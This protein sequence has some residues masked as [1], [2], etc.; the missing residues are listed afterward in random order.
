MQR[1]IYI[2]GNWK[3]NTTLSEAMVLS[4][5]VLKRT[6]KLHHINI[7]LAPPAIWLVPIR[8][9]YKRA[10]LAAQNIYSA[11][12]G[13]YTGEISALMLKGIAQYVI[14]GHSERRSLF[15]ED[16]LLISAKIKT[17]LKENITPILAIG[18]EKKLNLEGLTESGIG[19]RIHH[20]EL[21]HQLKNSTSG[22]SERDWRRLIIAYEPV[23]AIG[24]GRNASGA[25]AARVIGE[26]RELIGQKLA[27][28]DIA[29]SISILYGGSV[30][31]AS[32]PEYAGQ[33][34]IDGVLVGG[35]SLK[36]SKF[37]S[38]AEAYADADKWRKSHLL[39][40]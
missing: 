11:L 8:E 37:I 16:N 29:K 40:S 38:I 33:A 6:E 13:P 35:A 39:S 32:A 7:V 15:V 27:S 31:R 24:T 20:S 1:S 9:Q 17:A 22:L 2:V 3:M 5:S 18:E 34:E 26:L 10:K 23:W 30:S 36:A 12:E 4:G 19:Q 28:P 14:L 21:F 25:Y